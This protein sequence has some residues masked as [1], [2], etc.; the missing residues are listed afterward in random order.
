MPVLDGARPESVSAACVR[1]ETFREAGG[2]L[3]GQRELPDTLGRGGDGHRDVHRVAD[4]TA[5]VAARMTIGRLVDASRSA[6]FERMRADRRE[7]AGVVD[8]DGLVDRAVR[9]VV[10][11]RRAASGDVEPDV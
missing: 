4:H 3:E 9:A 2:M 6:V 8:D 1:S 7:A 5:V 11:D 10:L